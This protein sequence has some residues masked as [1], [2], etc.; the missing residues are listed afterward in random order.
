MD[1]AKLK[2]QLIQWLIKCEDEAVLSEVAAIQRAGQ[3][4]VMG[5]DS[6]QLTEEAEAE[7]ANRD[8]RTDEEGDWEIR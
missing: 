3:Q 1:K 8:Q 2:V 4:E 6:Q 5:E 7:Y